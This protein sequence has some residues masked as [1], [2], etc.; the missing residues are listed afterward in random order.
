M[1]QQLINIGN[2]PGDNTGDPARN[3]FDKCNLNFTEL[4]GRSASVSGFAEYRYDST[5]TPPPASGEIRANNTSVSAV[6]V[7]YFNN[8]TSNGSDIKRVLTEMSIGTVMVIQDQDNNVNFGKFTVNATPIDQT[9]YVQFPVTV[10]DS[11]GTL[12][13]NARLLV[14]IMGSGGGGGGNVS[15]VGTPANGQL[16]QWTDA[17]HI[18]GINTSTLGLAPLANPVF[19]GDPQAPTPLTADNDTSIATTAFVKAQ[20][21]LTGNQ[22]I[23]LSGDVTGSG[24]TAI[25]ATIANAAVTYAKMQNVSATGRFLGRIAA[26][27]GSPEELTAANG[28]TILGIMPAA[29][30][31]AHTGDV[32]NSA[33][34]LALTIANSAVTNAKLANMAAN[35]IK[36]NN[37]GSAAAPIDLTGAQVDAM[38]PVFTSALNGLA[39]LSGGGTTNFLRADGTWAAPAG[40]AV[41]QPTQ[42]IFTS[43]SG[44]YT[45]PANCKR[46]EVT[47]VGG[48]AGGAGGGSSPGNGTAGGNTT[49]GSLT[50][51]GAAATTSGFNAGAPGTASG[52][53]QNIGG[54]WGTDG[55]TAV[56]GTNTLGSPGGASYFGGAGG[57]AIARAGNAAA[58]NTGSGGGGGSG[59]TSGVNTG[60]GGSSGG[61]VIYYTNSPA[62][63]YSY[64]VGGAGNG[65]A[66]GS[67]GFAGGNGAAGIIIVKE[68]Y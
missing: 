55:G 47:C 39:P 60:A 36:G 17:T 6:T 8:I 48:G 43:G 65:G 37:T 40:G 41:T 46:I 18:Q 23:T 24:A 57:G 31:P 61:T 11:G 54:G 10:T 27:A 64:S 49:F 53:T 35:S 62:A 34:A 68:F 30:E 13:N 4:Y 33:G 26:G 32:T 1:A 67:G 66:A 16:A 58:A 22:T 59:G 38:L 20:G 44:T 21:Y 3:A 42:Q 63:T 7:L 15:N 50:A 29:N 5:T 51:G 12:F 52:G 2:A 9:T 19:T 25:T 28:W 56:T 14:A 45:L